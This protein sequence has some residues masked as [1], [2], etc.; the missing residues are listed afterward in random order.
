[1]KLSNINNSA[2]TFDDPYRISISTKAAHPNQ[3]RRA[4]S[5]VKGAG[6]PAREKFRR[7][8]EMRFAAA[9]TAVVAVASVPLVASASSPRMSGDEFLSA[10]RCTAYKSVANPA[11]PGT[12]AAKF[13][14]NAEF[15]LQG[16]RVATEALAQVDAIASRARRIETAADAALFYE[17]RIAACSGANPLIAGGGATAGDV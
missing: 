8:F 3:V 15:R 4:S 16:P 9:L 6:K 7:V 12:Y 13:T 14:L 5:L 1:M 11:D 10:V 2:L 17:E